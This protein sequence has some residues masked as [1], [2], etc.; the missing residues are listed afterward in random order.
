MNLVFRLSK[1]VSCFQVGVTLHKEKPIKEAHI[2]QA[3]PE[4][5]PFS[6]PPIATQVPKPQMILSTTNA[7]A[8]HTINKDQGPSSESRLYH[9]KDPIKNVSE[10][11]TSSDKDQDER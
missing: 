3:P 7:T 2:V 4:P 9:S 11:V 1:F 8:Q 6:Q 5:E 10:S